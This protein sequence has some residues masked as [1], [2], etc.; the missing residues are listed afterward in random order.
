MT[1]RAFQI[2]SDEAGEIKVI[3]VKDV[4]SGMVVPTRP[5]FETTQP[6]IFVEIEG[7]KVR[8]YAF[9][10]IV[11]TTSEDALGELRQCSGE[12]AAL[13]EAVRASHQ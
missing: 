6:G 11:H 12:L 4:G 1:T 3:Q 7:E 10:K 5:G 8:I 9:W 13:H 2:G